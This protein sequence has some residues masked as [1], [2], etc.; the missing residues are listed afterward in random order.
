MPK[1]LEKRKGKRVKQVRT[2]K[3]HQQIEALF[4]KFYSAKMAEGRAPRTL[5]QYKQN[6]ASFLSFLDEKG[7]S[8]DV[9][10]INVDVIRLYILYM[11][12]EIVR[13]KNNRFKSESEK[14]AGISASTINTRLRP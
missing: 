12:D 14:T 13:F 7:F 10:K 8:R 3:S 6:F 2:A 4:E 9:S 5:D 1:H 11:K